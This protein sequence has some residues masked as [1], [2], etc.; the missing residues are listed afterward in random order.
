MLSTTTSTVLAVLMLFAPFV[1]GCQP[2]AAPAAVVRS[3]ALA[4]PQVDSGESP[5][6]LL[7]HVAGP[8]IS[9]AIQ[10]DTAYLGHS[11]EL[12]VVDISDPSRPRLLSSLPIPA[13]EIVIDGNVAYVGGRQGLFALDIRV[14]A[15]PI[16]LSSLTYPATVA[17]VAVV[18][19]IAAVIEGYSLHLL[20]AADSAQ[21]HEVGS[22]VLPNQPESLTMLNGRAYVADHS[23]VR[24]VD[25][26]NP[27]QPVTLGVIET[28]ASPSK[29]AFDGQDG[30]FVSSGHI[31]RFNITEPTVVAAL[32][33]TAFSYWVRNLTIADGLAFLSA[34]SAGIRIWDISEHKGVDTFVIANN[35][36]LLLAG[37]TLFILELSQPAAP[38]QIGAV[39]LAGVMTIHA[40]LTYAY[41][42]DGLGDLTVLDLAD[43][44]HAKFVATYKMRGFTNTMAVQNGYAYLHQIDVGLVAMAIGV[45][46]QLTRVGALPML[47]EVPKIVAVTGYL[48]LAAGSDGLI[49]VDI[50]DP[51]TPTVVGRYRD[52]DDARDIALDGDTAFVAAGKAGVRVLDISDPRSP[53][54]MGSQPAADCASQVI[55]ANGRLY[56]GD[57]YGGLFIFGIDAE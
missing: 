7:G 54:P 25:A 27:R 56:V 51:T 17:G 28:E 14:P 52:I 32:N 11:F 38:R 37:G 55:V 16:L 57:A 20:D 43:A 31:Y 30:Y 45:D 19:G 49:V 40:N 12:D 48:L 53:T 47:A 3:S 18:A 2:A 46:G 36:A 13:T 8:M 50:A 22:M 41:L 9:L 42:V 33:E 29:L 10:G 44:D 35:R 39:A 23:G 34:G 5:L 1:S 15:S 21:M 26:S 24:I 6:T 4:I